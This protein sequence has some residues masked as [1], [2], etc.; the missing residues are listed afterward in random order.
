MAREQRALVVGRR[1]LDLG[2]RHQLELEAA[3][4]AAARA[5][6]HVQRVHRA[7][8]RLRVRLQRLL[9]L[10]DRH[11][12]VLREVPERDDALLVEHRVER[13]GDLGVHRAKTG[14][15][16]QKKPLDDGCER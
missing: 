11:P 4:V 14:G 2:L 15:G 5:A 1:A 7:R 12:V 13:G 8:V 3:G 6:H 16:A 9:R 10:L